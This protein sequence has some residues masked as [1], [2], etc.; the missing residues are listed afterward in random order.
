MCKSFVQSQLQLELWNK[1]GG[2][3]VSS[4]IHSQSQGHQ[5]KYLSFKYYNLLSSLSLASHHNSFYNSRSCRTAIDFSSGRYACDCRGCIEHLSPKINRC[6]CTCLPVLLLFLSFLKWPMKW[7]CEH[8]LH[9]L[10]NW[11]HDNECALFIMYSA[12]E[13]SM[14]CMVCLSV[15]VQSVFHPSGWLR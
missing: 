5:I 10:F 14:G 11:S 3:V 15:S 6:L 13:P 2:S 9:E 8:D 12:S 1:D 4:R 7:L